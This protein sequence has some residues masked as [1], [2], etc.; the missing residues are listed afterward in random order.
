MTADFISHVPFEWYWLFLMASVFIEN[1]FPPYPG[2]SVVVFAG[3]IAA[4]G[5]LSF[6]VLAIAVV[7]G[8]LV[9]ALI[10]YY[11]GLEIM[12]FMLKHLKSEKLKQVFSR[13]TLAKTHS[14]FE[15]FGFWAVI[16]SRFSAGIRFFIA[17]IA[18]MVNMPVVLFMFS[19]LIATIV[20]NSL[21]VY[22]GYILGKNWDQ[23]MG[24][25]QLYSGI[26]ALVIVTGIVVFFIRLSMKSRS[27]K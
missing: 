24:Y 6:P 9:S 20:W 22:G 2:D 21:L 16:F 25:I 3:Y 14:W 4:T 23:L 12:D 1:I 10:M 8:N 7:F 17:I 11:F 18:G 26:V 27:P 15:R 13:E 19:F 5:H